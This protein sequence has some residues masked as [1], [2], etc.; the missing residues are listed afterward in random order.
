[1][2]TSFS[3][4]SRSLLLA[5]FS[6]LVACSSVLQ[7]SRLSKSFP[8]QPADPVIDAPPESLQDT[9][10]V[11]GLLISVGSGY[12]WAFIVKEGAHNS[13]GLGHWVIKPNN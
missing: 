1:M 2:K 8:Q 7:A 13:P 6:S 12:Q 11:Y 3:V 4:L 9:D 10:A 5:S